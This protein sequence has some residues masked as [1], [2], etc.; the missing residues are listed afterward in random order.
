MCWANDYVGIPYQNRGRSP[1]GAD[2]W[3]LVCL[4]YAKEL[5]I[6]LPA[7][8]AQY[9]NAADAAEIDALVMNQS[10]LW[11]PISEAREFDL[12]LLRVGRHPCHVGIVVWPGTM[13]HLLRGCNAVVERYN[14]P[15]WV[16]RVVGIFRSRS[17]QPLEL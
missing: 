9:Q 15:V 6:I 5:S 14:G 17:F 10:P 1:E 4:V 12:V 13:L 11:T 8:T 7:L 2:C 3:G 16:N